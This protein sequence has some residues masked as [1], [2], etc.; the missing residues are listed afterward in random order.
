MRGKNDATAAA[1]AAASVVPEGRKARRP[2]CRRAAS[3]ALWESVRAAPSKWLKAWS[4]R[5]RRKLML[6]LLRHCVGGKGAG[7]LLS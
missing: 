4:A 7:L 1:A 5:R 6:A 3:A 2:P